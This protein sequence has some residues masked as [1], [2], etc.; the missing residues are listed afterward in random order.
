MAIVG[1]T[2]VGK[3][4]V[5]IALARHFSC[6]IVSADSR[7][8]YQEMAI[9]TAKPSQEELAAAPHHLVDFLPLEKHLA[10][11][12]FESLAL[13]TIREL[14]QTNELVLLAGGSGL[15]VDAVLQ[16]LDDLPT[17]PEEVRKQLQLL[18]EKEGIE[19]LQNLVKVKDPVFYEQVD[20]DN[21]RRL[22]R[23][24]EVMETTGKPF[25]SFHQKK[26]KTRPFR[27]I[28]IGLEMDREKL[29]D[30]INLRVDSMMENGLVQEAK[31]LHERRGLTSLETVGYTELFNYLEGKI[32]LEE[33]TRLIK[34]NSRRYAKRQLTWWRKDPEIHWF[35]PKNLAKIISFLET[36]LA[37]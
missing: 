14:P 7:Q 8:F 23:A 5:T 31:G 6:E 19:H 37:Q 35:D 15:Y 4:A 26:A 3:T 18:L 20:L 32:S 9:G 24:L 30:R 21:P 2:A 34:R 33:A 1:P 11:G 16:G 36:E 10:A 22:L 13:E 12:A 29:Y 25:S 27:T 28:K 17:T